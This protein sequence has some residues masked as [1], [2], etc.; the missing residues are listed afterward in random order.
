MGI[1][2]GITTCTPQRTFCVELS[3][4]SSCL[5]QG[6]WRELANFI[7]HE[8]YSKDLLVADAGVTAKVIARITGH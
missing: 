6:I 8:P 5:F 2:L 4:P 7:F 1:M 3:E